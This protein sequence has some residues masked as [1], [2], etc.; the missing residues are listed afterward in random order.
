MNRFQNSLDLIPDKQENRF[1]TTIQKHQDKISFSPG[2]SLAEFGKS[3]LRM[4]EHLIGSV[5]K[6]IKFASES[7]ITEEGEVNTLK[8]PG[9][10]Y[11]PLNW[12]PILAEKGINKILPEWGKNNAAAGRKIASQFGE[13]IA[14]FWENAAYTGFE[15][16]SEKLM[17]ARQRKWTEGSVTRAL[18][19]IGDSGSSYVTSVSAFLLTKNPHIGLSLLGALSAANTYDELERNGVDD[20]VARDVAFLSGTFEAVTEI[21]PFNTIMGKAGT[22]LLK[23]FLKTATVESL[24]EFIQNT[25]ENYFKNFGYKYDPNDM[26]SVPDALKIEWG[27]LMNGWFEAISAGFLMGGVAGTFAG[28]TSNQIAI[29]KDLNAG[30]IQAAAE[31]I[32]QSRRIPVEQAIDEIMTASETAEIS[33]EVSEYLQDEIIKDKTHDE[34]I[35]SDPPEMGVHNTSPDASDLQATLSKLNMDEGLTQI[36]TRKEIEELK[37]KIRAERMA[38]G[39]RRAAGKTGRAATKARKSAME[40]PMLERLYQLQETYS[41]KDI[42]NLH[43]AIHESNKVNDFEKMS[44]ATAVDKIFTGQPLSK[45]DIALI[46]RIFGRELAHRLDAIREQALPKRK[47]LLHGISEVLSVPQSLRAMVDMGITL[48]QGIVFFAQHPLKA[49]RLTAQTFKHAW[50]EQASNRMDA[51]IRDLPGAQIGMKHG[52]IL[53]DWTMGNKADGYYASKLLKLWRP[54]SRLGKI[55]AAPY[56]AVIHAKDISERAYIL[57]RNAIAAT[58]YG[59]LVKNWGPDVNAANYQKMAQFVNHATGEGTG[60]WLEKNAEILAPAFWAPRLAVARFQLISD[61]VS[62]L[63]NMTTGKPNALA[64]KAIAWEIAQFGMKGLTI[65]T[66]AAAMGYDAEMDPRAT[67]FGKIKVGN[68]RYDIWGGYS[69]IGKLVAQ[70]VTG[71]RKTALTKK[72]KSVEFK[73]TFLR[74]LRGKLAPV[75][76]TVIDLFQQQTFVGEQLNTPE[77]IM[78]HIMLQFLPLVWEDTYEGFKYQTN[79]TVPVAAGAFFGMGVSTYP[80]RPGQEADLRKEEVAHEMFQTP[81]DQ[82]GP[83]MQ[84]LIRTLNP[85]IDQL[86]ARAKTERTNYD[87]VGKMVKEQMDAGRKVQNSLDPII[88][89]EL[90]M[91]D[92]M[93]GG[94]S[95]QMGSNWYLNDER[96][97]EYQQKTLEVLQT[98][99]SGVVSNPNWQNIPPEVRQGVLSNLISRTKKMVR[100]NIIDTATISDL[101]RMAEVTQ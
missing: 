98:V 89:Q 76:G 83:D 22:G 94:L 45:S 95:R 74:F 73:E 86:E 56:N 27:E 35:V 25:G 41:A 63:Y 65:M 96:Y 59:E 61:T 50:T 90:A 29:K 28:D 91:L 84:K 48:R 71:Q 13:D 97:K 67:E 47:G 40:G 72:I 12:G 68:T 5:G 36:P 101:L 19:A 85:E 38:E 66:L 51:W 60:K 8:V 4:P 87:F 15:A 88:Q 43:Q 77:Q 93:V 37:T 6:L 16:P 31:S 42:D 62:S 11:V 81:W 1:S 3:L 53:R 78:K 52:L 44:A 70:L 100:D 33:P 55:L 20:L 30:D 79:Q 23:K 14:R 18:T 69:Q 57:Q 46:H 54:K 7:S 9:G 39:E 17:E 24:Q 10:A 49:S 2:E 99:L 64:S 26:S 80:V 34:K 75:P 82:L 21:I 92:V 32:A 58:Y